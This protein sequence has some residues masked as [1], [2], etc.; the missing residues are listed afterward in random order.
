[1][2]K[3]VKSFLALQRKLSAQLSL[4]GSDLKSNSRLRL[5][6]QKAR[7]V[8]MPNDNVER[9]IKKASS[10]DQADYHE[11]NMNFMAMEEWD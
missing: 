2:R 10:A 1:M 5:A 6:I 7:D 3:R 9:N 4:E 11:M 8:N